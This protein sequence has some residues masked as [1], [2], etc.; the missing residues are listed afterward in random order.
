MH[1]LYFFLY[2]FI[3]RLCHPSS[4]FAADVFTA[5]QLLPNDFFAFDDYEVLSVREEVDEDVIHI[6]K[7]ADQDDC[8]N[9][10]MSYSGWRK[11]GLMECEPDD[12]ESTAHTPDR[13]SLQERARKPMNA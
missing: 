5:A 9:D 8:L 12:E 10:C 13:R 4:V 11:D 3:H 2:I 6:R 7:R 1:L